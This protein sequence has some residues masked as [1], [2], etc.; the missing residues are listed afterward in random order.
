LC[1][2]ETDSTQDHPI[3]VVTAWRGNTPKIALGHYLQTLDADFEKAVTGGAAVV[4]KALQSRAAGERQ[5]MTRTTGT[6]EN[7]GSRRPGSSTGAYCTNHQVAK[8]GLELP[9]RI[10]SISSVSAVSRHSSGAESGAVAD[11]LILSPCQSL[12]GPEQP[13]SPMVEAL[14]ALAAQLSPSDRATLARLLL[15]GGATEETD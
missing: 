7:K 13:P 14:L 5:E 2:R 3:H 10:A 8:V 1:G 4:Q 15:D 11:A 9:H 12:Q 6:L